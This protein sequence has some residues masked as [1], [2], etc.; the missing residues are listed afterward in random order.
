M[1]GGIGLL[2][3]DPNGLPDNSGIRGCTETVISARGLVTLFKEIQA[4]G[5]YQ[6]KLGDFDEITTEL[7][8]QAAGEEDS[9]ALASLEEMGSYLGQVF[10]FFVAILNPAMIVI[11]GGLGLATFPWV[12][13]AAREELERRTYKDAYIDL[14]IVP[15]TLSSSAVGAACLVF[16]SKGLRSSPF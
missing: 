5:M 6:S 1:G 13:P 8:I 7:I 14:E 2:S 11:S 16:E 4:Q 3:L 15:S 9:L 10:S 12:I